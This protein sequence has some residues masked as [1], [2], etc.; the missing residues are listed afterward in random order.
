MLFRAAAIFT[1]A[2]AKVQ[3]SDIVWLEG[4][5]MTSLHVQAVQ[6]H[7]SRLQVRDPW[8]FPFKRLTLNNITSYHCGSQAWQPERQASKVA[9]GKGLPFCM[10]HGCMQ[11][12]HLL[13]IQ[14]PLR[15]PIKQW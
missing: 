10:M 1:C 13:A 7:V 12:V 9:Q 5:S 14:R 3:K 6:Y 2:R 11:W 15:F 8:E 4:M